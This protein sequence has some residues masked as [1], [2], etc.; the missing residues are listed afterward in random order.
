MY[1]RHCFRSAN[2]L[3]TVSC[4]QEKVDAKVQIS[5]QKTK[6]VFSSVSNSDEAKDT[7]KISTFK[8]FQ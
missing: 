2:I 8:T 4:H 5:E 6:N 1:N 7:K 3:F